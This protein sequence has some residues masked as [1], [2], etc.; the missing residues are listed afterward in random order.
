MCRL[1]AYLG[2]PLTLG[3]FLIDPPHSLIKQSWA[4]AEMN[5]AK[6]NA[7]GFGF[8]WYADGKSATYKNTQPIWSDSNLD[9]LGMSLRSHV[10]MANVRSATPGQATSL[11]NTQPFVN[12]QHLYLHNGYIEDFNPSIRLRFHETL[13][14][15]IQTSIN[16]H[17][18][19]EYIFA[20]IRQQ[21]AQDNSGLDSI[22]PRAMAELSKLLA[23]GSALLNFIISDGQKLYAIRHATNAQCPS[24]YYTLEEETYPDAGLIA[25]ECLT[26]SANWQA[27][28]EHSLLIIAENEDPK[29]I[30]L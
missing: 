6:L 15:A 21:I 9:S 1:A 11:D 3:Q 5:E 13:L 22:L 28:E 27:V 19:S 25:S 17:T 30:S 29:I 14:P 10:W 8:G 26:A 7:D 20:I 2:P 23:E 18:D 24:L 12:E 16:G 4:P